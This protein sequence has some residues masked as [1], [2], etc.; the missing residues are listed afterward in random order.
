[1]QLAVLRRFAVRLGRSFGC[2]LCRHEWSA[3]GEC[4]RCGLQCTHR[5][6]VNDLNARV[7]VCIDCNATLDSNT[8]NVWL[9]QSLFR[10]EIYSA[11]FVAGAAGAGH[12]ER[13][14]DGQVVEFQ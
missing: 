1:M 4:V 7:C 12:S 9:V 14:V 13:P 8:A 11:P 10:Y 3:Q 2:L 6:L 5:V